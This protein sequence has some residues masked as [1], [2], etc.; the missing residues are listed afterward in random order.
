V[1]STAQSYTATYTAT[2]AG[3]VGL[4]AAWGFNET[5][6]TTATDTSGNNNTATLLNGLARVAGK[7]GNGL[8]FDGTNDYL[9]AADSTSLSI[10]GSALTLSMWLKPAGGA[11]D[12]VLLGKHWNTSMT[13]PYYQYGVELQSGATTPVFEIG[14]SSGV[15][16]A[17]MG[18]ALSTSQWSHLAIVFNGTTV[19]FYVNGALSSTQNLSATI[20]ARPN[21]L[22]MGADANTS[23]FYRGL[24][25]DVRIYNRALTPQ[26]NQADM[27]KGL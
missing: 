24:L 9:S 25:D 11:G 7:Y 27:A 22:R 18:K 8:S 12:Q 23:Q 17:S 26:E 2:P 5:S 3:P 21:P 15:R 1:P 4:A 13:S 20:T 10:T 14:T 16:S 6:G 19:Q